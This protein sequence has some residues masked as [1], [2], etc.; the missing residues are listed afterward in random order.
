[1]VLYETKLYWEESNYDWLQDKSP[2]YW[3]GW[4]LAQYQCERNLRFEDMYKAGLTFSKT[5]QMYILHEVDISKFYS[6]CDSIIELNSTNTLNMLRRLRAY[7]N[8]TQKTLSEKS[9]VSLRMIQ[10]Y[11]QGQNSLGKAQASVVYQLAK[12]LDC[13]IEDLL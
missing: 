11:E 4:A 9:G 13:R 8:L 5:V 7:H 10:L 3:A 2:E 1:M 12:A 6:E